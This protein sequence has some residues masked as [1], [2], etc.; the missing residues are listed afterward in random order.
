MIV[1]AM[2][3]KRS[4]GCSWTLFEIAHDQDDDVIKKS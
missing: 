3:F 1:L 2:D 4:V